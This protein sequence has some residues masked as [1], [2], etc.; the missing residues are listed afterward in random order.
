MS[1]PQ[2]LWPPRLSGIAAPKLATQSLVTLLAISSSSNC[3]FG[4]F[5]NSGVDVIRDCSLSETICPLNFQL[6]S[7][8]LLAYH[9]AENMKPVMSLISPNLIETQ[10]MNSKRKYL[11]SE[12]TSEFYETHA[13]EHEAVRQEHDRD[14]Q[15]VHGGGTRRDKGSRPR[16]EGWQEGGRERRAGEDRRDARTG[17]HHGQAAPHYY[18][19]KRASP[20][21]ETLVRDARLCQGR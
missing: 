1:S 8:Q 16:D 10:G 2:Q 7:E 5:A 20:K 18:Q 19:R 13:E 9:G 21:A 6:F 14:Q 11:S 17:S 4:L 12:K 3:F 15:G